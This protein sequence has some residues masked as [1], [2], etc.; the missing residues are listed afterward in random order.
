MNQRNVNAAL[1]VLGITGLGIFSQWLPFVILKVPM[2]EGLIASTAVT[3][4][5]QTLALVIFPYLWA[6]KRLGLSL[7]DLGISRQK[8]GMNT[9]LGCGLY[10]IALASFVHCS[11]GEMMVNHAVRKIGIGDASALVVLMGIIAAGTDMTTRGFI[12]LSL[13]R[14]SHVA[15]AIFMQNL[16]WFLGHIHEIRLLAD[17]LGVVMATVLTLTLGIVGDMIV[18]RTRNV[19]GLAI[20]HFLLNVVLAI[21]L[22]NL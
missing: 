20:A 3:T 10:L 7:A 2:P 18:L 19:I 17:C 12:L 22:R 11:E 21:Y 14:Y 9:L 1:G 8:L 15:F 4:F 16:I 6:I 5:W 13:A